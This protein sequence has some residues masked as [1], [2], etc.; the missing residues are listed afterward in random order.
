MRLNPYNNPFLHSGPASV[1]EP[2][3]I[4]A[5]HDNLT[6]ILIIQNI[7]HNHIKTFERAGVE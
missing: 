5:E 4:Q 1:I 7:I 2:K 6:I 3:Q